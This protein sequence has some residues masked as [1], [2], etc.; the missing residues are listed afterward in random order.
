MALDPYSP[1]PAG[2]GKKLKFCCA[3][4]LGELDK[5]QRMLEGDQRLACLEY[6][7]KLQTRFPGRAC[8]LTTQ[9]QLLL[10]LGRTDEA[11]RV[12]DGV[13]A[14]AAANPVALAESAL[15]ALGQGDVP[16]AIEALQMGI[17]ASPNPMPATVVDA[18]ASIGES[19]I[20]VGDVP[21][22]LGHLLLLASLL[23]Q[24]ERT[25]TLLMRLNASPQ[26]P[27]L[28]KEEPDLFEV[29]ADAP[30][31]EQFLT[32][33]DPA[34]RGAWRAAADN[35]AALG[36]KVPEAA[37][38]WH[39][40]A[41]LQ[42][43][44]GDHQRA[45]EALRYLA[46]LDVS[47]D[48]QVEAEAL[49]QL[50][51][52]DSNTERI[53]LLMVAYPITNI[54]ELIEKL[55]DRRAASTPVDP[56]AWTDQNEP[57]PRHSYV[58]LDR[59]APRTGAGLTRDDVPNVLGH[60]LIFGRQTDR[61]AR[62]EMS[63]A[64]PNL[65]AAKAVLAELCAAQLGPAGDEE[66]RGDLP[67]G[68][69][70]LS[71][72]WRLPEDTPVDQVH[73][74]LVEQR[75]YAILQRWPTT[76]LAVLGGK[77]PQQAG[78]DARLQSRLLGAILILELSFQEPSVGDVFV[79]LRRRLEL[80]AATP[81]ELGTTPVERVP[82]ARLHRVDWQ[83]VDDESMI[84]ANSRALFTAAQLAL[85]KIVLAILTRDSL[86]GKVNRAQLYGLLARV[87]DD[88]SQA[89]Q[90]LD[91]ARAAADEAKQSTAMLD[92][93]EL[94][95][96]MERGEP[97]EFGRVLSHIQTHHAREPGVAH[98]LMQ[99]L[100]EAGL[101]TPDGRPV[102]G[103]GQGEAM[104]AP[105]PAADAGKI[106]TPESEAGPGKKSALWVPGAE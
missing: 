72:N 78:P 64:R 40:L 17:A 26:V 76:P 32:A 92:L 8:L 56:A 90:Y 39:S 65:A 75:R 91:Q 12:V 29:P 57:P 36:E 94:A 79:E 30:W 45:I 43:W 37:V 58:L 97:E 33:V 46:S 74:L 14:T 21:T 20:A 23:P 61:E 106:W 25:L 70:A 66:K 62:L 60:V 2:T 53:D 93:Q 6:I 51:D 88:T 38:V 28:F 71:W 69:W 19:L 98:A 9:A 100:V 80:P 104:A 18:I 77:T 42:T 27:L 96:R 4:L 103:P 85:R 3:D 31:R 84:N 95:L 82:L 49:A 1:C 99:I 86:K 48:E 5:I 73:K 59:P 89:I 83:H 47:R 34:R 68:Q 7:E 67:S 52:A 35:L 44:L 54:D 24:D 22:A 101:M 81:I 63:V 16:G 87:E 50:L 105:G 10:E 41:I 55:S 15:I 13:L 11:K 102:R